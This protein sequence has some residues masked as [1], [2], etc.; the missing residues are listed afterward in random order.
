VTTSIL[1]RLYT[2]YC[3]TPRL[4]RIYTM[5]PAWVAVSAEIEAQYRLRPER[6]P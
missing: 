1:N 5:D 6:E 2:R 4:K 3:W